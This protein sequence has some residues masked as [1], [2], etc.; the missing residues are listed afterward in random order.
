VTEPPSRGINPVEILTSFVNGSVSLF[1]LH[2]VAVVSWAVRNKGENNIRV[3]I[4]FMK[5]LL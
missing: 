3:K 4:Y 2:P 5:I 1:N